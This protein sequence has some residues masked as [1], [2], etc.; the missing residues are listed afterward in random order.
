MNYQIVNDDDGHWYVIPA[1]RAG[2]WLAWLTSENAELGRI[3]E[4]AEPING[5]PSRVLFKEYEIR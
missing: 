3:P 2:R 5:G 4:W 1:A